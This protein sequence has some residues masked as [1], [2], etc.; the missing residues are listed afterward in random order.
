MDPVGAALAAIPKHHDGTP[1]PM[2]AL[3]SFRLIAGERIANRL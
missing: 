1:L 2:A 3:L